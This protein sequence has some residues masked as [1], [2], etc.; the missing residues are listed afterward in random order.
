[1]PCGLPVRSSLCC[2]SNFSSSIRPI[3]DTYIICNKD[4]AIK[5]TIT[6]NTK[7]VFHLFVTYPNLYFLRL[8]FSF[9][10]NQIYYK[11]SPEHPIHNK[12]YR[13][14]C[15]I[16]RPMSLL[17]YKNRFNLVDGSREVFIRMPLRIN[18]PKPQSSSLN[19]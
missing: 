11:G 2:Q 17:R 16:E 9:G 7:P 6:L 8:L 14:P 4:Y 15:T 13:G 5:N 1:M 10:K 12:N 19:L 3:N 18:T